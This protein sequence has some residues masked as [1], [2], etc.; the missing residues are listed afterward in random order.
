MAK[1]KEVF[2]FQVD[3]STSKTFQ[4]DVEYDLSKEE[5]AA[6]KKAGAL[7]NNNGKGSGKTGTTSNTGNSEG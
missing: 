1:L 3:P 5:M 6:A 2:R 7:E 4:P